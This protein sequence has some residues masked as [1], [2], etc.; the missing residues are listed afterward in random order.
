MKTPAREG[1]WPRSLVGSVANYE[2]FPGLPCDLGVRDQPMPH[3]LG[4]L[5]RSRFWHFGRVPTVPSDPVPP[6]HWLLNEIAAVRWPA[7]PIESDAD[8]G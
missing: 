4:D 6:S 1:R 2:R 8:V 3:A 7:L 5:S